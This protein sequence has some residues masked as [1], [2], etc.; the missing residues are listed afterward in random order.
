MI[1][2]SYNQCLKF[3]CSQTVLA[4]HKMFYPTTT[5]YFSQMLVPFIPGTCHEDQF[6]NA[7]YQLIL[8]GI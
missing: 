2:T 5:I 8:L 1:I 6:N 4:I 7:A 3:Q